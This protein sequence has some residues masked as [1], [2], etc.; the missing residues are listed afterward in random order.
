VHA[1]AIQRFF[2][3]TIDNLPPA[4]R[5]E[6]EQT[7]SGLMSA[8][9]TARDFF[10]KSDE[11]SFISFKK[12][13]NDKNSELQ[14]QV[15]SWLPSEVFTSTL[16]DIDKRKTQFAHT[17]ISEF[18][19]TLGELQVR[20]SLPPDPTT[21]ST[22]DDTEFL[23]LLFD[24]GLLPSYAFPTDLCTFYV[25]DTESTDARIKEK[26]QQDKA[27]ALSE[28]APGRLL[29]IDK[30]TYRV[31]GIYDEAQSMVNPGEAL[32]S[33]SLPAYVYC[34]R[35]TYIREEAIATPGEKC[36]VCDAELAQRDMLDPPGF[37]PEKGRPIDDN[38]RDQEYTYTTGAQLPTPMNPDTFNWTSGA[39]ENLQHAYEENRKLVV[40]NQGPNET[41][42]VV[43]EKCGA[44]GPG[45]DGVAS[46]HYRP[47]LIPE[48]AQKKYRLSSRCN[49]V[50]R[51]NVYL[52]CSF[53]TDLLLVRETLRRP[54]NNDPKDPWYLDALITASE[55]LAIAA[56]RYL[57][58]DPGDIS[59]NYRMM[60]AAPSENIVEFYLYDTT[61]GGAGYAA[62]A[63][64]SIS[65]VLNETV[66]LLENCA[67]ERSC[68][69]CLRHYG[70]RYIHYRLD[71]RLAVQILKYG[72]SGTVPE[73][74]DEDKQ[75]A[76]L[77]P[78]RSFLELEGWNAKSNALIKEV[79][80]P[81]LVERADM[82]GRIAIGTYLALVD[83]EDT[84]FEHPLHALDDVD[85]VS[86]LLLNDY[87][88]SRDLPTAYQQVLP[89]I[90]IGVA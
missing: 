7:R 46:P 86:I 5:L 44:A 3:E 89:A 20:W 76:R 48:W 55:A 14:K 49:G 62:E 56:S 71:R 38:D 63:G 80:V 60:P 22:L 90:G 10:S 26:P 54:M 72:I 64:E 25:F 66:A 77:V 34:P 32:F 82:P 8:L 84:A 51:S 21:P 78:L 19:Q 30:R 36:P 35:C 15:A 11:F 42:F 61:S 23:D 39:G 50:L 28:Y 83:K 29:V 69:K 27:K 33:T 87:I 75:A 12:W 16:G 31:G 2:H 53:R 79:R 6:I 9:G 58:I 40:V 43:C 17:V 85:D 65:E 68:N 88:A 37:S 81:L 73:V 59:A 45:V 57:D 1:S 74:E 47:Y 18:V 24:E 70:N 52:G 4:K 13:I 41:G 67:C